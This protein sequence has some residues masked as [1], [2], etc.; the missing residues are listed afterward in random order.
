MMSATVSKVDAMTSSSFGARRLLTDS[1]A[2]F[3]RCRRES[4]RRSRIRNR[5]TARVAYA[6]AV[7]GASMPE[8]GATGGRRLV[9]AASRAINA[10]E[11]TLGVY[12][13][14]RG[15]L[16]REGRLRPPLHGAADQTS[17]RL[18]WRRR[19]AG[20][21]WRSRLEAGS[22]AR[23]RRDWPVGSICGVLS[24]RTSREPAE[25]QQSHQAP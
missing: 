11:R 22:G 7:A 13:V 10:R 12:G 8:C 25:S 19:S 18:R 16:L 1:S 23:S 9:S 3:Q 4:S 14:R 24:P 17:R 6:C 2:A 20:F 21:R 5:P 15:T